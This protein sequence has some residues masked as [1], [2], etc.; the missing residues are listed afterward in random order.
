ME[1]ILL[2]IKH[3][4][5]MNKLM[6]LCRFGNFD[7]I[8]TFRNENPELDDLFSHEILFSTIFEHNHLEI[9]KWLLSIKPNINIEPFLNVRVHKHIEKPASEKLQH[10]VI[11]MSFEKNEAQLNDG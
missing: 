4:K 11:S 10:S 3:N 2:S 1:E 9:A 6:N 8:I 7:E 5:L